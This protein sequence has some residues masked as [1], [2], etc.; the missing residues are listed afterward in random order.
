MMDDG[1]MAEIA[2][3]FRVD[4]TARLDDWR[5]RVGQDSALI[6]AVRALTPASSDLDVDRYRPSGSGPSGSGAAAMEPAT[7]P[8]TWDRRDGESFTEHVEQAL[9]SIEANADLNAFTQIFPREALTQARALDARLARGESVGPF[10]GAI[11]AVKDIMAVRGSHISGGTAALHSA[12]G[13]DSVVVA[14]LRAAGG[15]IIGTANLHAL[16][17]GPFSTSSDFGPV[18]NPLNKTVVAGGSSGGSAAA[19]ASGLADIAVGTDTAGSIRMPAALCGVVGLK[20]TY[21]LVPSKGAQP[22]AASLD[23]I[24]PLARTVSD[25]HAALNAMLGIHGNEAKAADSSQFSPNLPLTGIT[26]GLADSYV[27]ALLTPPIRKAFEQAKELMRE[28]GAKV[29][30]LPLPALSAAPGIMLCTLGRDAFHTFK[31]LLTHRASLLPSDVRLRL[32]AGMFITAADYAHCQLLRQDLRREVDAAF[33][34]IDAILTPTM[35]VTAPLLTEI[36]GNWDEDRTINFRGAMNALTLPFNLTGHPAI[37]LPFSLDDRGAGIG[38]QLVGARYA[39]SRLLTLASIIEA[40]IGT[41][42]S[43]PRH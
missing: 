35:A 5:E 26:I 25:A 37:S 40:N 32:E 33:D 27:D 42:P 24:G 10:A 16:A 4:G 19:V 39:D 7:G 20:P 3:S 2:A 21:S 43:V 9:A 15:I 14:R 23:H 36:D 31:D 8:H 6:D 34:Q 29:L 13:D 30:S 17:Y 1:M 11:V 28:L 41:L 38:M 22:L 18:R 12:P